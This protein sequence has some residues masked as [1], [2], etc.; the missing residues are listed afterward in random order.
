[1]QLHA[2]GTNF[3]IIIHICEYEIQN[4]L[5]RNSKYFL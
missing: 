2:T 5:E 1:M 4:S 3:S